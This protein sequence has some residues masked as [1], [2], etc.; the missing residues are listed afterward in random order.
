MR[1]IKFPTW[2]S[3]KTNVVWQRFMQWVYLR[4]KTPVSVRCKPQILTSDT[5]CIKLFS[6]HRQLSSS[7]WRLQILLNK[8]QSWKLANRIFAKKTDQQGPSST[9]SLSCC[10]SPFLIIVCPLNLY[11]LANVTHSPPWSNTVFS[12]LTLHKITR[13]VESSHFIPKH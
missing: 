9:P 6:P 1:A 3:Q 13:V 12:P 10:R 2:K 5:L 7:S 8:L 11:I 4:S